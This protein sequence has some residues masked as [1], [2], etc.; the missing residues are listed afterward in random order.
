VSDYGYRRRRGLFRRVRPLPV[1]ALCSVLAVF[2]VALT[3]A[4]ASGGR[5]SQATHSVDPDATDG[6]LDD[7]SGEPSSTTSHSLSPSPSAAHP[8]PTVTYEAEA[9]TSTLGG[10]ARVRSF[11][12]ASGQVGV[13]T[14][15][16]SGATLTI[17]GVRAATGGTYTVTIFYISTAANPQR[18]AT[19]RVNNAVSG[20]VAFPATPDVVTVASLKT[21]VILVAGANA[22]QFG[23]V[24]GPAP[25]IDRISVTG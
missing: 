22:I 6:Y 9:A 17:N 10:A 3:R 7:P 16:G 2:S 5:P 25:D 20:S 14:N 8:S 21:D 4:M 24:S 18:S 13:V 23:N 12:S 1:V 19:I 11:R 15:L